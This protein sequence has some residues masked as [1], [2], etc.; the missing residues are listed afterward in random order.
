MI[1]R[2][3]RSTRT[4]TLFP[5]TTLFR[6]VGLSRAEHRLVQR[7]RPLAADALLLQPGAEL[8]RDPVSAP[9]D[10]P[11]PADGRRVPLPDPQQRGPVRRGLP[12]RQQRRPRTAV[13]VRRPALDVQLAEP[14]RAGLALAR[15]SGLHRSQ[16]SVLLPGSGHQ[17]GYRSAGSPRSARYAYLPRQYLYRTPQHARL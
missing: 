1:R 9:D 6:S 15:R 16:R 13:R 12:G 14:Y 4:V 11:R 8:R 3:P 5:Y 2:P 17:S 7:Y 10:R